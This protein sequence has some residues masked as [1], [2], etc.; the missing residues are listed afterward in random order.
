VPIRPQGSGIPL[1]CVHAVGGHVL[2]YRDLARHLGPGSPFYALQAQGLDG[3]R[4]PIRRVEE[5]AA[6]YISEIRRIQPNGPYALGG[7]SFGGTVAFEMA[8]QLKAAGQEVGLLVLIDSDNFPPPPR[9]TVHAIVRRTGFLWKRVRLHGATLARL[10]ARQKASY[11]SARAL[12]VLR[13]SREKW[14]AY[15]EGLRH[16]ASRVIDE[17]LAANQEAADN[18]VATPYDG[19]V[20]L[21][22]ASDRSKTGLLDPSLGWGG[23]CPGGIEVIEITGDHDTVIEEPEVRTLARELTARLRRFRQEG[24]DTRRPNVSAISSSPPR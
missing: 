9:E 5:M 19:P 4:Q 7:Y 22:R 8:K 24:P 3:E 11:L 13:W 17:V 23:V 21:F 12:T 2:E 1:F 6:C 20:L 16:P 18:Y 14:R 15:S 10:D